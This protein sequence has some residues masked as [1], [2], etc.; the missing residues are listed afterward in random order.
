[1]NVFDTLD[2]IEQCPGMRK[3]LYSIVRSLLNQNWNEI[4]TVFLFLQDVMSTVDISRPLWDQYRR[5]IRLHTKLCQPETRLKRTFTHLQR[6]RVPISALQQQMRDP[7][8][9]NQSPPGVSEVPWPQCGDN[10]GGKVEIGDKIWIYH[11][12][13]ASKIPFICVPGTK[14][15]YMSLSLFGGQERV[16]VVE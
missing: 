9:V 8:W 15:R 1:M 16:E 6:M 2:R 4:C 14:K 7:W 11:V 12:L 10:S 13:L 5:Q 3:M